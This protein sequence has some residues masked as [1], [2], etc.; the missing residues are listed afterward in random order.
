MKE[1]RTAARASQLRPPLR[2]RERNKT[3]GPPTGGEWTAPEL[4]D[5]TPFRG[6][7]RREG[8]PGSA[9]NRGQG[10]LDAAQALVGLGCGEHERRAHAD[11]RGRRRRGRGRRLSLSAVSVRLRV[12]VSGRSKATKRP[13]PRALVTLPGKSALELGGGPSSRWSPTSRGVL[14]QALLLD[15]LEDRA[16]SAPCRPGCRPRSS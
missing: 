2:R 10:A 8:W 4:A 5:P 13:R 14:E 16:G 3:M 6:S 7:S 9:E 11:R 12:S 1:A 15:D